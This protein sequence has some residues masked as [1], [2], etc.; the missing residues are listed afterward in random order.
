MNKA[1]ITLAGIATVSSAVA[2]TF[3]YNPGM[4][5]AEVGSPYAD[6]LVN[7]H[8]CCPVPQYSAFRMSVN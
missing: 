3:Y 4:R 2:Q 1:L 6:Q 8:A 5:A 7:V